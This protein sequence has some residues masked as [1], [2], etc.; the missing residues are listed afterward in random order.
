MNRL[1]VLAEVAGRKCAF[2]S[3]DVRS[4]IEMTEITPVPLAPPHVLGITA[5]RSQALT[6]IDCRVA[7]GEAPT[8]W[9]SESR[10]AVVQVDGHAYALL[11]DAIDDVATAHDDPQNLPGGFGK[12]WDRVA[13]GMVETDLG[14]ML[15]LDIAALI[16]AP[17]RHADAA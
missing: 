1:V 3:E 10:A 6:V 7:V 13:H 14:P 12:M 17:A 4:V 5:L 2:R 8:E 11:I 16:E 9:H 15:L